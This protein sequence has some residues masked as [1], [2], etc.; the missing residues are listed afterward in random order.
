MSET[1]KLNAL[2]SASSLDGLS[3]LATDGSGNARTADVR[4]VAPMAMDMDTPLSEQV[5]DFNDFIYPGVFMIFRDNNATN[6]P[7]LENYRGMLEVFRRADVDF[8]FQRMTTRKG[9]LF[10]RVCRAGGWDSWIAHQ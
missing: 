1:K 5:T 3:L 6:G 10:T 7:G 2:S 8:V 4:L 9:E